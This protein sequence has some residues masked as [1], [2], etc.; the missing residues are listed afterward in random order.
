MPGLTFASFPECCRKLLRELEKEGRGGSRNC[1][2]GH[3]VSLDYARVIEARGN[4]A[5]SLEAARSSEQ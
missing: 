5:R 2:K 1:P 4:S 3:A